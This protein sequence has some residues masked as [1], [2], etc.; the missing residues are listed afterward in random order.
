MFLGLG[1]PWLIST[2]YASTLGVPYKVKAGSLAFTVIVFLCCA[3]ACMAVL[4]I[5]RSPKVAGAELGGPKTCKTVTAIFF[6]VLWFVF[7]ALCWWNSINIVA[8]QK[9][10]LDKAF[11]V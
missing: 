2:I 9:A 8:A 5:R 6:V 10:L 11:V 3:I 4:F 7:V 1:I